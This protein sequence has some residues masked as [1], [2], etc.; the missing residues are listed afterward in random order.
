MRRNPIK[1]S[2]KKKIL[3]IVFLLEFKKAAQREQRW[4]IVVD[5]SAINNL[6]AEKN[7][8]TINKW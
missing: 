8:R 4:N 5:Y 1:A 7:L 2:V 6:E 3:L